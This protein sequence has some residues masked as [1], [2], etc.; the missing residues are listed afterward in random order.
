[1]ASNYNFG[2]PDDKGFKKFIIKHGGADLA[3]SLKGAVTPT[4]EVVDTV[5]PPPPPAAPPPAYDETD[6]GPGEVMRPLKYGDSV[7]GQAPP[8]PAAAPAASLQMPKTPAGPSLSSRLAEAQESD[9]VAQHQQNAGEYFRA[10]LTGQPNLR[11]LQNGAVASLEQMQKAQGAD[12]AAA[13]AAESADPNSDYSRR[14]RERFRG[15]GLGGEFA[16]R[17]GPEYERLSADDLPGW[18]EIAIAEAKM[19][20]SELTTTLL[21][22]RNDSH[23]KAKADREKAAQESGRVDAF[24]TSAGAAGVPPDVI[25]KLKAT[26]GM[27]VEVAKATVQ[28]L[29]AKL[30]QDS[31]FANSKEGKALDE[32]YRIK[33]EGRADERKAA[34]ETVADSSGNAVRAATVEEAKKIREAKADKDVIVSGIQQLRELTRKAGTLERLAGPE[35]RGAIGALL[36]DTQLRAK[37]ESLYKLGVLSGPDMKL[38]EKITGDPGAWTTLFTGVGPFMTQLATLEER[39]NKAYDAKVGASARVGQP[40]ATKAPPMTSNQGAPSNGVML[41]DG[42]GVKYL[43]QPGEVDEYLHSDPSMKRVGK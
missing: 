39:I 33:T 19:P 32:F 8:P 5:A 25:A 26:P 20:D 21:Q 6:D 35:T 34:E 27:T 7:S 14:A 13:R 12:S 3:A 23:L 28:P 42:N 40:T 1:M 38:L 29:H 17:M 18:K 11:P 36:T 10:A 43:V 31:A 30:M 16:K 9:R 4:G 22:Q 15:L 2:V 24:L 37:G 41:I